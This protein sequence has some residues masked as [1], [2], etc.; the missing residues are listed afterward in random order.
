MKRTQFLNGEVIVKEGATNSKCYIVESGMVAIS[1]ESL[2]EE[3]LAAK[4][5]V[6]NKIPY[7]RSSSQSVGSPTASHKTPAIPGGAMV[8]T[9]GF[10]LGRQ[11]ILGANGVAEADPFDEAAKTSTSTTTMKAVGAVW[12]SHFDIATF[13]AVLGPV[14]EVLSTG[15]DDDFGSGVGVRELE[16]VKG[17]SDSD[18]EE[19]AFLGE[20]AYGKVTLAKCIKED[21][22]L[23][24]KEYAIKSLSKKQVVE[25]NHVAQVGSERDMLIELHHPFVLGME[26]SFQCPDAVYLVTDYVKSVTL[27]E[28][29]Y[30]ADE[31]NEIPPEQKKLASRFWAA[32]IT[33]AIVHVHN[34]GVAYRDLKPENLLVNEQGYIILIDLGFAKKLPYTEVDQDGFEVTHDMTYTLCGTFEYLAPE[35]F[36][37]GHGHTHAV[38]YW[39]LGCMVHE[40]I[41]GQ[42]PFVDF[43]GEQDLRKLFLR[44]CKT[45]YKP[46]EF[47][48]EFDSKAEIPGEEASA[49]RD[50]CAN[51]LKAHPTERLGN[52]AGGA[53]GITEHPYFGN[54]DWA[55]MRSKEMEAP[56]LPPAD[57]FSSVEKDLLTHDSELE[58]YE[59][60]PDLFADW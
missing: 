20:G 10:F 3:E 16:P 46:V 40:M 31:S 13:E 18:F 49:C 8:A 29:L 11:V 48:S 2:G 54:F 57:F 33:E 58:V 44:I 39:A 30:P 24:G 47:D 51:L 12:V 15:I 37:D 27:F 28:I 1:S 32:N 53:K 22:R 7:E 14:K 17:L 38:D 25:Q 50:L 43:P 35:F 36:Y 41:M 60:D 56:W 21:C 6:P 19:I 5:P 26:A 42:T 23:Y 59:G 9:E 52:L 45:Q 4:F 55:A 34:Q